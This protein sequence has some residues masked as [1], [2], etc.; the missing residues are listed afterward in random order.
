ML[1]A[2]PVFYTR[3][4]DEGERV[5]FSEHEAAGVTFGLIAVRMKERYEPEKAEAILIHYISRIRKPFGVVCNTGM[6]T[7]RTTD[8]VAL[9]DY[10]QDEAGTDWKIRGCSDGKLLAV[11][12]VK[13]IGACLLKEHEDFLN[14][15]RFSP[16][17]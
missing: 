4:T 13:N 1:S 3:T 9:T 11:L 12:Y 16:A 7:E 5:Y 15:F 2:A 10:W 14:G 17:R 6:E 8:A